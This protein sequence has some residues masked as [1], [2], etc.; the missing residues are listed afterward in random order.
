M[1]RSIWKR[2]GPFRSRLGG[3][4]L[5]AA[6]CGLLSGCATLRRPDYDFSAVEDASGP[7]PTWS[8]ELRPADRSTRPFAVTNQGMQIERDLGVY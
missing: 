7:A 6:A 3:A 1:L 5:L 4:L 2:N 8:G